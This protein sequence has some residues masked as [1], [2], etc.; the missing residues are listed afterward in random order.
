MQYQRT[1][2]GVRLRR[3]IRS[4]G[5]YEWCG[6]IDGEGVR[7]IPTVGWRSRKPVSWLPCDRSGGA[8]AP[9]LHG[10]GFPTLKGAVEK[11]A[12]VLREQSKGGE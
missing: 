4:T 8:I 12:Q 3:S 7:F 11:A 1:I 5:N 10:R 2:G 6:V 9:G